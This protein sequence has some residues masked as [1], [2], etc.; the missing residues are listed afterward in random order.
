MLGISNALLS[1]AGAHLHS[2]GMSAE[3]VSLFE[4]VK[5]RLNELKSFITTPM[6]VQPLMWNRPSLVHA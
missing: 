2:V 3:V 6:T 4:I 1:V 5:P